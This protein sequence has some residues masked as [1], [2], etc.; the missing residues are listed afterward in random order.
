VII[1]IRGTSGSGKTTAVRGIMAMYPAEAIV[2]LGSRK[3]PEAYELRPHDLTPNGRDVQQSI[4]AIGSYEN[5]CGGCDKIK[6][7]DEICD[8]VRHYNQ[9]GHVLFEGLLLS[10]IFD[11]YN[12]LS[13]QLRNAQGTYVWAF[14]DTPAEECLRR[15]DGRRVERGLPSGTLDPTKT[16]AKW[17]QFNNVRRK[18]Q[19]AGLDVR[20]LD[21][22]DP[23]PQIWSWLRAGK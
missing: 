16:T 11:R 17:N 9:F 12:S 13:R 22:R 6:T 1:N 21:H 2:I 23:V 10:T 18:A 8:L 7:Q 3:V 4:Y 15:I 19:D 20:I 5:V 14:L